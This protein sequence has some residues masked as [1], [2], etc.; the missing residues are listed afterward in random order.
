MTLSFGDLNW[1]AVVAATVAAVVVGFVW[2]LPQVFGRRWAASIGRDLPA[3]GDISPMIYIASVVQALVVAYVLTLIIGGLGGASLTDGVLVGFVAWLG[4]GATTL[5][6]SVLFEGRSLDYWLIT[7][8]YTLVAS[9]AM[10]A[11]IGYLGA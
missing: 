7:A 3:P 5:L 9:L 2:Y 10:G 11:I 8:G 6:S 4:F 1:I